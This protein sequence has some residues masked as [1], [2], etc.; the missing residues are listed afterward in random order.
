M[1]FRPIALLCLTFLLASCGGGDGDGPQPP[2]QVPVP[3]VVSIAPATA[4]VSTSGTQTFACS[5]TGA[6]NTQC[7]WTANGGT[8]TTAG[9]FTAPTT[10]GT[11]QVVATSVTDIT[12]SA[13]ATVTVVS[14]APTS[15][16]WVTG[17]YA[18]WYWETYPPQEVDMSAMTHFVF[19]RVAPGSGTLGGR[20]GEI[21][22]GAGTAQQADLPG[23]P[24]PGQSIEDYLVSRAHTSGTKALLMLGG[25]GDGVGF[26]RSSSDAIRPTFVKNLV[27]YLIAHD[28]DG[29]DLDWED[30]LGERNAENLPADETYRRLIALLT[31][32]RAEANARPRYQGVNRFLLTFPG[33]GINPNIDSVQPWQVKV[34]SLSDQYNLMSY[35][36][37]SAFSGGGWDSW[38][39]SPI[40]GAKINTP[41][42]L[43]TSMRLYE[44][45]G[46]P[47]SKL[48]IGIG[49]FGMYYVAPI[50]RPNMPTTH[51]WELQA[52]DNALTYRNLSRNGYLAAGS[53]MWDDVSK[54]SYITYGTAGYVPVTD[55]G[56]RPAGYLSYETPRSIAAK[57]DWV[58][59]TGLGGTII[60]TIDYG[61]IPGNGA[62]GRGGTNPLLAATKCSFLRRGC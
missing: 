51:W 32:V 44:Q 1:Y 29:V 20:P 59:E 2:V 17:Y 39:T 60:W 25:M 54:S 31:E 42:D 18:G 62:G 8:V 41:V 49:F 28:Y 11:S 3:V 21:V 57:A 53:Q 61:Y 37:G 12:K 23:T 34:A 52:D 14:D 47:R 15:Q 35:G 48:G 46:V 9:V 55:P 10:A 45:A 7:T 58:R 43:E 50:T 19:G 56:A 33:Y 26:L 40:F 6:T 36:I 27:D 13:T 16:K 38:F 30:E 24:N 5:V 4:Q 22:K